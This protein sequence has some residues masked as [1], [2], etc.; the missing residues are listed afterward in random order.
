MV[1]H[2][3]EETEALIS[4]PSPVPLVRIFACGPFTIEVLQ[5][6]PAGD[7]REARYAPLP[8]ER[9]HGRGP[10]PAVTFLKLLTSQRDRYAPKDWL[11]E[12]LRGDEYIIT[13][14]RLENIVS[15]VR[16]LL[17]LPDGTRPAGMLRYTR[18]SHESGDGY[19]LAPYPL[20]W[21]DVEAL[22][23]NVEQACRLER[24]GEDGLPFWERAYELAR[25]GE[26]LLEEPYTEWTEPRRAEVRGA[27][28]QSVHA[29]TRA[30]L[31]RY[32]ESGQAEVLRLLCDYL[33]RFPMDEDALRQLLE[34]LARQERFHELAQWFERSRRAV[35]EEG[36]GLDARTLDVWEYARTK[37]LRRKPAPE[38]ASL[39]TQ[40]AGE[41]T[42]LEVWLPFLSEAITAGIVR[43]TEII[44][45]RHREV[46]GSNGQNGTG[47]HT[48]PLA[49]FLPTERTEG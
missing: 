12:H 24:F 40:P 10:A 47:S 17:S 11:I 7:A 32:G 26:Y 3:S 49:S 16:H 31:G 39:A 13:P 48:A 44:E 29:L 23:W 34:L 33:L 6:V 18:A 2:V 14:K 30:Y 5:E 43:A 45:Q 36:R 25:R 19:R 8:P 42:S 22:C 1:T 46:V 37:Q 21:L 15:F 41:A 20:I 35:E 28:G 4:E 9:L 38:P 27:L